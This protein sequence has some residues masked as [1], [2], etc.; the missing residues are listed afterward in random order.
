MP[1]GA[2]LVTCAGLTIFDPRGLEGAPL[3][4]GGVFGVLIGEAP[5]VGGT[6]TT[7][8]GVRILLPLLLSLVTAGEM[9]GFFESK[10]E[11]L[12]QY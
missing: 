5:A 9:I 11:P 8:G 3:A 10:L 1:L 7:L 12:N 4:T 6:A 2:P